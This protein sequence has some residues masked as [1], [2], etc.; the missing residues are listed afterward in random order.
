MNVFE[1]V[2]GLTIPDTKIRNQNQNSR[3]PSLSEVSHKIK[4]QIRENSALDIELYQF[5]RELFL[6][7]L[8]RCGQTREYGFLASRSKSKP[9]REPESGL[10]PQA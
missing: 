3:R 7:D 6:E 1:T 4:D 2:T 8:S 10:Q 5:G 9:T